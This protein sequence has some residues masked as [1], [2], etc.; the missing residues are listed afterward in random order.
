MEMI[1]SLKATGG[2]KGLPWKQ[3]GYVR[4]KY[5][6][7]LVLTKEQLNVLRELADC[8]PINPNQLSKRM[9]KAYSFVYN[10]LKDFECRKIVSMHLERSKKGT[11]S[12][13]YD[14]KLEGILWIIHDELSRTAGRWN[15]PRINKFIEKHSSKLPLVFGK[16]RYFLDRGFEGIVFTRLWM[17]AGTHYN[18]PFRRGTG[19]YYWLEMEQQL[20]RFFFLWDFYRVDDNPI[21]GF[22]F[23]SWIAA[24][25]G[26]DEIKEFVIKEL[27]SD[28][29]RLTYQQALVKDVLSF[30]NRPDKL[31]HPD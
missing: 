14:L 10:T 18:N 31:I 11:P 8:A 23:N 21:K 20:S 7:I 16:W 22:D 26:D 24:L 19:L 15:R 2:V 17:L 13:V 6:G 5:P 9:K 25:K 3:R 30:M 12:R 4:K 1:R 28:Q 29:R 27:E